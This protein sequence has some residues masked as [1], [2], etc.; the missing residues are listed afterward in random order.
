MGDPVQL[1]ETMR[2]QWRAFERALRAWVPAQGFAPELV[3]AVMNEAQAHYLACAAPD[4]ELSRDGEQAALAEMQDWAVMVA[5][6]L[7]VRLVGVELDSNSAA[8]TAP[9]LAEPQPGPAWSPL[10]LRQWQGFCGDVR[11]TAAASYSRTAVA[12][13]LSALAPLWPELARPLPALTVWRTPAGTEQLLRHLN[14][15]A[16]S[17]QLAMLQG[18]ARAEH[19]RLALA[20]SPSPSSAAAPH[21]VAAVLPFPAR[22]DSG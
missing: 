8:A 11:R 15:W 5:Y 20:P 3:D 1:P 17:K 12:A 6:R 22:A 2:P 21:P 16:F 13:A 9:P 14:D 18:L 7:A 4:G 19:A 10:A